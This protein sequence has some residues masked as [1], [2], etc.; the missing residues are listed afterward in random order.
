MSAHVLDVLMRH[1]SMYSM[2]LAVHVRILL[3]CVS[4][5]QIT[6]ANIT[7]ANQETDHQNYKHNSEFKNTSTLSETLSKGLAAH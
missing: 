6:I 4:A 3:W 5:K 1:P 2:L 7:T